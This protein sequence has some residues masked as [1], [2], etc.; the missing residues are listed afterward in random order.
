ML[1]HL[2]NGE[3]RHNNEEFQSNLGYR[4]RDPHQQTEKQKQKQN[5][6]NKEKSVIGDSNPRRELRQGDSLSELERGVKA[7]QDNL[8]RLYQNKR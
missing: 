1:C 6:T 3:A 8:V 4:T 7:S 5:K 2:S